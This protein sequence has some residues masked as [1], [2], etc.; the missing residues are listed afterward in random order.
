M[1]RGLGTGEAEVAHVSE[2]QAPSSSDS[3]EGEDER[4]QSDEG[5]AFVEVPC[6]SALAEA[7]GFQRGGASASSTGGPSSLGDRA[8]PWRPGS[9]ASDAS[10]PPGVLSAGTLAHARGSCQPCYFYH[11]SGG[12]PYGRSCKY[13]HAAHT[14][15]KKEVPGKPKRQQ[16]RE[17]VDR[18]FQRFQERGASYA[19]A[20]ASLQRCIDFP[21]D[22]HVAAKYTRKLL[23]S[24]YRNAGHDVS[25]AALVLPDCLGA[26]PRAPPPAPD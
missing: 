19:E 26:P 5:P 20:D 8:A 21:R 2:G 18:L 7:R 4:Q 22:D 6:G 24:V 14:T 15:R 25:A 11:C 16:C 10:L 1:G 12:C 17:L 13:C 9:V 23:R 3:L